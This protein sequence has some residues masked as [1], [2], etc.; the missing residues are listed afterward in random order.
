MQEVDIFDFEED[1]RLKG[2]R[3]SGIERS[4]HLLPNDSMEVALMAELL[5]R[6]ADANQADELVSFCLQVVGY[7]LIEIST[8]RCA[9]ES[10][11]VTQCPASLSLGS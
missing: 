9:T 10:L 6:G 2:S 8:V 11:R 1:C 4:K 3:F 7:C 5:H